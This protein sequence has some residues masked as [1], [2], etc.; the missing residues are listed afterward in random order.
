MKL[1]TNNFSG[2]IQLDYRVQYKAEGSMVALHLQVR[3]PN[4]LE[5]S[6]L[7]TAIGLFDIEEEKSSV[8]L[9]KALLNA[10][11]KWCL[12]LT[13]EELTQVA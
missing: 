4:S 7:D 13:K 6:H 10:E 9:E 5:Y 3:L 8:G 12:K 1:N 2:I 11:K